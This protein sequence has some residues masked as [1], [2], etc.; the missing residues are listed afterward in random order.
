MSA[1]SSDAAD[2]GSHVPDVPKGDE[3]LPHV[4][5][6]AEAFKKGMSAMRELGFDAHPFEELFGTSDPALVEEWISR[7]GLLTPVPFYGSLIDV[8]RQRGIEAVRDVAERALAREE[9]E[10]VRAHGAVCLRAMHVTGEAVAEFWDGYED[11][12]DKILE[13]REAI[14]ACENTEAIK[15]A[16][17]NLEVLDAL[18]ESRAAQKRANAD[19]ECFQYPARF[20]RQRVKHEDVKFAINP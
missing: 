3:H 5:L 20:K 17:V 7:H 11:V 15:A 1:A 14:G 13:A 16:I 6:P 2:V 8:I 9:E 18:C 19:A 4:R 10:F 12:G